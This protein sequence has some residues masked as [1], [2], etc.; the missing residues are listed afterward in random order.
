MD[1]ELHHMLKKGQHTPSDH[2]TI[3]NNS[4]SISLSKITLL[5]DKK[6]FLR[7]NR[8]TAGE[9]NIIPCHRKDLPCQI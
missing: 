4:I 8:K 7:Q 3:S 5:F 1:I 9:S 2:Q 6:N